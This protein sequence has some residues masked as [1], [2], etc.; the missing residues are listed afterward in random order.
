MLLYRSLG[1]TPRLSRPSDPSAA[2]ARDAA[3]T[4]SARPAPATAGEDVARGSS[5]SATR[6]E[7]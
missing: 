7:G 1:V 5:A 6:R 2:D 3:A 4:T